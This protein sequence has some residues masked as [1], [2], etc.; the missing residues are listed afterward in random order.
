M[1][2]YIQTA[3]VYSELKIILAEVALK[4]EKSLIN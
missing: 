1:E 2:S 3:K 4:K